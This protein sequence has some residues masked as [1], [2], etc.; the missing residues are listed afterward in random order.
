MS[1]II[2]ESASS[3][4]AALDAANLEM[5]KLCVGELMRM[6]PDHYWVVQSDIKGGIIDV[7]NMNISDAGAYT[8]KVKDWSPLWVRRALLTAGGELLEMH[9]Q[10][11]GA[12]NEMT[13][14]SAKRDLRGN[15]V[16]G[17]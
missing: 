17:G 8:I 13:M 12:F 9:G 11:R 10:P 4:D 16:R 1:E 15:I 3:G 2:I 6:Y 14:M 7:F 5:C